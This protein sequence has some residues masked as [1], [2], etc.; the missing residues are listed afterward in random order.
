LW[1]D[2]VGARGVPVGFFC[3]SSYRCSWVGGF[4]SGVGTVY[5]L[6][7]TRGVAGASIG[8]RSPADGIR[9]S[10]SVWS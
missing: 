1:R 4:G 3:F 8:G 2:L 7:A 6:G 5:L 9:G 10:G